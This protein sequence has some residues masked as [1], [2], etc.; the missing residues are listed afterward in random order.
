MQ[1]MT[2]NNFITNVA[3]FQELLGGQNV[4]LRHTSALECLGLF[5]GYFHEDR[6]EV[7]AMETVPY[8]NISYHIVNTF[9]GID[10]VRINNLLCTSVNRTFND[11]L[12]KYGTPDEVTIDEQSLLEGLSK[13]YYSNNESFDGLRI[14]PENVPHFER[15]KEW[16]IEYYDEF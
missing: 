5:T 6:I 16:A 12:S 13:Y 2:S 1:H 4:I 14:L 7:Y 3:W 9:D 8:E 11:M 10:T 15:L